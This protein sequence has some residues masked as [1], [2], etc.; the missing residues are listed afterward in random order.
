MYVEEASGDVGFDRRGARILGQARDGRV[1]HR[2]D[3]VTRQQRNERHRRAQGRDRRRQ[4]DA[5]AEE[6]ETVASCELARK[7]SA[8]FL[9]PCGGAP[10]PS[11][12]RRPPGH[13]QP[14]VERS[15]LHG[16]YAEVCERRWSGSAGAASKKTTCDGDDYDDDGG[17]GGGGGV[18]VVTNDDNYRK[19]GWRFLHRRRE[20]TVRVGG[21]IEERRGAGSRRRR[22]CRRRRPPD[23]D[24]TSQRRAAAALAEK[25]GTAN[26]PPGEGKG[27]LS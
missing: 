9:R 23:N 2:V 18:G 4:I 11:R 19:R 22:Q 1:R 8:R 14:V 10:C 20:R 15:A 21:V 12:T 24:E 25:G 27:R 16:R 3:G 13:G 26:T 7:E 5:V 6:C 17:G